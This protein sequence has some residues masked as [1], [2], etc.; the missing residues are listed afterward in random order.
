MVDETAPAA[1]TSAAPSGPT[2][3]QRAPNAEFERGPTDRFEHHQAAQRA[4]N[5][6]L[7]NTRT[8][9]RGADGKP[10]FNDK[11]PAAKPD[12]AAILDPEFADEPQTAFGPQKG[13]TLH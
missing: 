4:E 12:P 1:K 5:P 6:W 9:T 3:T 2:P 10:I 7:D 8:I 13:A 11:V